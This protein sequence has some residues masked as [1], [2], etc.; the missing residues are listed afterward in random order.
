MARKA[1]TI[2][3]LNIVKVLKYNTMAGKTIFGSTADTK[4]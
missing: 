4:S 2:F 1:N 3:E